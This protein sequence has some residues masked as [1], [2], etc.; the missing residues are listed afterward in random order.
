MTWNLRWLR[1]WRFAAPVFLLLLMTLPHLEQGD[2]DTD[3]ARYAAV[4]LQAWRDGQFSALH[5]HPDVA[6]LKKPPLVFWIHGLA[7]HSL[8]VSP[9]AVRIPGILAAAGCILISMRIA[10]LFF[11]RAVAVGTGCILA[12]TVDFTRRTHGICLDLWLTLFVLMSVRMALSGLIRGRRWMIWVAGVPLGLALLCKPLVGLMAVPP[13]MAFAILRPACRR[14]LLDLAVAAFVAIAI[15][16]PWHLKMYGLHG[17]DFLH[18]YFKGEVVDRAAGLIAKKPVWFYAIECGQLYLPWIIPLIAAVVLFPKGRGSPSTRAGLR[19]VWIWLT[20]WFVALSLFPDK[21]PRYA[22]PLYPFAAMAAAWGISQWRWP[23]MLTWYRNRLRGLATTSL[24]LLIA[25]WLLPVQ[26]QKPV[27]AEWRSLFALIRAQGCS[28]AQ[29]WEGR[30][31]SNPAARLYLEF[32]WWPLPAKLQADAWAAHGT[33]TVIRI[34]HGKPGT[35]PAPPDEVPIFRQGS[36]L[37]T[38]VEAF[39]SGTIYPPQP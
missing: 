28:P 2:Y 34:H 35:F 26:L 31:G 36:L 15:A 16:S 21:H 23:A 29:V 10:S 8:G 27:P 25:L 20:I 13:L 39:H 3:T 7:L 6:Y 4:G 12:L 22:M 17:D 19:F 30:I 37:V 18:T 9:A 33:Q 5:L 1:C 32:G 38:R 24:L 11:R 14:G